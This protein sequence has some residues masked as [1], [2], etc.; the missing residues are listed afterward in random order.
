LD[1]DETPSLQHIRD[2]SNY[3]FPRGP[4]DVLRN[5]SIYARGLLANAIIIAPFLL[6]FAGITVISNTNISDLVT[7]AVLGVKIPNPLGF[8]HF[9]VTK[10]L[11]LIFLPFLLVWA[12]VKSLR[13]E[14]D[15]VELT[16]Y[17]TNFLVG[18]ALVLLLF[19]AFCELQPRLLLGM[20]GHEDWSIFNTFVAYLQRIV[21][22]F[23]PFAAVVGFFSRQI[24]EAIKN[25]NESSRLR[26]QMIGYFGRAAIWVAA[27][28][29]PL[30][31][32]VVYLRLSYWG[33]LDAGNYHAPK[34][35]LYLASLFF[36]ARE[37][38]IGLLY[39]G[40]AV[41]CLILS[42]ALRPNANSLHPLYRDRLSKAFL[43]KPA[44]VSPKV[45]KDLTTAH[46]KVSKL[47]CSPGPYH[48]LNSA[49]N[50]QSSKIANRRGR[51]A[52]FF[53]F[54]GHFVGS[55]TTQY[56]KTS[57]IEHLAPEFDL[58]TA[59]AVSGAAFSPD[60]GAA[61]IRV[62]TP[63]LALLNIRLGYWLRNPQWV[64]KRE[65]WSPWANFYYLAELFGFLN[66]KRRS[67]YLT[68]GGHIENLGVYE[69]LKRRCRVIIAVDAGADAQMTFSSFVKLE[70]FARIDLG[71]RIE[72]PWH[73]IREITLKAGQE[74]DAGEYTPRLG[75]HCVIGEIQYPKDRFGILIYIKASLTGD[76]NDYVRYYRQ[77]YTQFPHE[78]TLDQMF[79]EE[80]FEVYRALGF[81][82]T[83]GF[84]DRRDIFAFLDPGQ[85]PRIADEVAYLD[86]LFPQTSDPATRRPGQ[87]TTFIS[88]LKSRTPT[89]NKKQQGPNKKSAKPEE[90]SLASFAE[91][92]L[93]SGRS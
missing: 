12:L 69:L 8:T 48:I 77:R 39:L 16:K 57:D 52:D 79:S 15:P 25:A 18:A 90:S 75:P 56:V 38:R 58:A 65:H 70:R 11:S 55:E 42:V 29:V 5:L 35:L 10:Y 73:S 88:A 32:W 37:D 89:A 7:P 31:L 23:A 68:D 60:M 67:V 21:T 83:Y 34:K 1:E 62:L 45:G 84:F 41:L 19:S 54:S 64:K 50:I 36:D 66:E 27:A 6:L 80:Q 30:L 3:L 63:T 93:G 22:F 33:I 74:M 49:L 43:F 86:K 51:N 92:K 26:A 82:A 44:H 17:G 24:G 13:Y 40:G 87:R 81:H 28:V 46:V 47:A 85:Y 91:P 61:T 20:F 71:I 2:W 72:L 14:E 59:M 78:T 9:G 4:G 53:M 76:E